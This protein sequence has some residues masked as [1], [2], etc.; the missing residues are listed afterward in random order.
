M[1]F[2]GSRTEGQQTTEHCRGGF[3][4]D[5]KGFLNHIDAN[6]DR[7]MKTVGL[8]E[9]Y[10]HAECVLK[11]RCNHS[12]SPYWP[13]STPLQWFHFWQQLFLARKWR[14]DVRSLSLVQPFVPLGFRKETLWKHKETLELWNVPTYFGYLGLL[15]LTLALEC[16]TLLLR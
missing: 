5:D 16:I 9:Q 6:M 1:I 15:G 8:S 14:H 12:S 13:S 3:V 10:S 4:H 11:S 7:C 2:K